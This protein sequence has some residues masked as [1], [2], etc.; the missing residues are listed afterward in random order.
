MVLY[1][2]SLI[3][4]LLS[5]NLL[6]IIQPTILAIS[7][8]FTFN[9]VNQVLNR[10]GDNSPLTPDEKKKIIIT[11]FFNPIIAGAFYYYCW[12]KVFP[13]KASQ[14]NKYSWIIVG[15]Q[16]ILGVAYIVYVLGAKP[17]G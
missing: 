11:E 7:L 6:G 16:L 17:Q 4:S 15:I 1:G 5:G 8:W 3:G 12:K 2:L 10:S 13:T 14:A 9:L